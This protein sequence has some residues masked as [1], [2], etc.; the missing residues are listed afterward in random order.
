MGSS[1][2]EGKMNKYKYDFQE[3]EAIEFCKEF[4]KERKWCFENGLD[5]R[6]LEEEQVF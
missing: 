4:Q 5:Y 1:A 2:L 3:R 6:D